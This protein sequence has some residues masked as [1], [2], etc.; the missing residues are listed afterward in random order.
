M[1]SENS[2]SLTAYPYFTSAVHLLLLINHTV[3]HKKGA[4]F[5]NF[6]KNQQIL[7]QFS[8]LDFEMNDT[9]ENMNFTHL[10]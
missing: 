10:T 8:L 5:C 3:G 4:D 6:V 9:C 1:P 7:M 2:A